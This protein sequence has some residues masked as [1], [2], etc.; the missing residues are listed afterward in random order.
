MHWAPSERVCSV[1]PRLF[2]LSLV[3][4]LFSTSP[5]VCRRCLRPRI[6]SLGSFCKPSSQGKGLHTLPQQ[7]TLD[8]TH[9]G[10]EDLKEVVQISHHHLPCDEAK[11]TS[12]AAWPP[13]HSALTTTAIGRPPHQWEKLSPPPSQHHYSLKRAILLRGKQQDHGSNRVA[14][15]AARARQKDGTSAGTMSE[16]AAAAARAV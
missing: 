9:S 4:D 7:I 5:S 13:R 14:S 10:E 12:P 11:P 3:D 15:E 2:S 6:S 16:P 8:Y 1:H